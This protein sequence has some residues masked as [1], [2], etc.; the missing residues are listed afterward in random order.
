MK[1][2][3]DVTIGDLLKL[4]ARER[5]ILFYR[6]GIY[7]LPDGSTPTLQHCAR[8]FACAPKRIRQVER[9]ALE[10]CGA[11]QDEIERREIL[12]Q[13]HKEVVEPDLEGPTRHG[14]RARHR[15][16]ILELREDLTEP[17]EPV[18]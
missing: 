5:D 12:H 15:R 18:E 14:S 4:T 11:G 3:M 7:V 1:T 17:E 6:W 8:Y 16:R 2:A 13:L 10:K 9:Q